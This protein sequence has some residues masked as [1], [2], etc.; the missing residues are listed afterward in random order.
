MQA[1]ARLPMARIAASPRA[2]LPMA[3]WVAVGI[4]FAATA[5]GTSAGV[6]HALLGGFGGI[7]VP[8][9]SFA[10]VGAV[11]SGESLA[12]AIRPVVAFGASPR[13]AA[14]AAAGT[15]MLL[16]GAISGVL[17]LAVVGIAGSAH[18][19]ADLLAALWV[20]ALGGAVYAAWFSLGSTFG[21]RS[22]GRATFLFLDY[23]FG[24]ATH[25]SAGI[26]A[27][28]TPRGNLH[29]LLGGIA[30][31]DVSQRTSCAAL[32]AVGVVCLL[33]TAARTRR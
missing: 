9:L 4:V 10:A 16:A 7:A 19:G 18:P 29:H 26:S 30:P 33:L 1:L 20:G 17:G 15:A 12:E 2:W 6:D 11:L 21:A 32:V 28:F 31:A 24:A 25:D 27:L 14:L 3:A 23:L 5:R 8:L 22:A 13:R